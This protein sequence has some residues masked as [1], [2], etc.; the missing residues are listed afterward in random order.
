MAEGKQ[1]N[2]TGLN[3]VA[4]ERG[5]NAGLTAEAV[6]AYLRTVAIS[7]E[8]AER[9]TPEE[10]QLPDVSHQWFQGGQRA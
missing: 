2:Q 1:F 7:T 9:I 6:Q 3:T 5:R 8:A 4:P 10:S